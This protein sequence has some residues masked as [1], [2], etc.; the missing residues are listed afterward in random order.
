LLLPT[1][2]SLKQIF[3][4]SNWNQCA[5]NYACCLHCLHLLHLCGEYHCNLVKK[6]SLVFILVIPASN[7]PLDLVSTGMS[8]CL[9]TCHCC[10]N[11]SWIAN[12]MG[13]AA[14]LSAVFC[15]RKLFKS[16][17]MFNKLFYGKKLLTPCWRP[18]PQNSLMSAYCLGI[19]IYLYPGT[20][21]TWKKFRTFPRGWSCLDLRT[22][23]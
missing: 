22:T 3:F 1:A 7:S 16:E 21:C 9:L 15:W 20:F 12:D 8:H 18:K 5:H 2:F 11:Y 10:K 4:S 14:H 23:L 6:T 17:T 19:C 13:D